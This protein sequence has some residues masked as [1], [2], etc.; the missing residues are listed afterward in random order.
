M[1]ETWIYCLNNGT[2]R[3]RISG[4][5]SGWTPESSRVVD[6]SISVQ[7]EVMRIGSGD[8]RNT[9]CM[10]FGIRANAFKEDTPGD[11]ILTDLHLGSYPVDKGFTPMIKKQMYNILQC[12]LVGYSSHNTAQTYD[13]SVLAVQ[14]QKVITL[15]EKVVWTVTDDGPLSVDSTSNHIVAK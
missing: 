12:V 5:A 13:V 7:P 4:S 14:L 11:G 15:D 1:V 3:T 2:A 8:T 9:F 10:D 6:D